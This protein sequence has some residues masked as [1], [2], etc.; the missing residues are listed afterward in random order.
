MVHESI[1]ASGSAIPDYHRIEDVVE[2]CYS[3]ARDSYKTIGSMNDL[4]YASQAQ[5]EI[6]DR[7]LDELSDRLN[8]T[9][10]SY[11]GYSNSMKQ[12]ES[13]LREP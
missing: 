8:E 11:L 2:R 1:P 10:M 7:S 13:L 5:L 3:W 12:V 6:H 9:P 4:I